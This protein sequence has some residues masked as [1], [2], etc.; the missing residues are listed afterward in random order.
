M[1]R[2]ASSRVNETSCRGILTSSLIADDIGASQTARSVEPSNPRN[3]YPDFAPGRPCSAAQSPQVVS[4]AIFDVARLVE[5]LREQDLEP[6]LRGWPGDRLH[7]RVPSLR[8]FN[9][10]RQARVHKALRVRNRPLVERG[11]AVRECI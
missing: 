2:R 11:D 7:A 8:D 10:R 1:M 6:A 9:V 5:P 4:Q 3:R